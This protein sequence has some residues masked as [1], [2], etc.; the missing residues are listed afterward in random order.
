VF[1]KI[2]WSFCSVLFTKEHTLLSVSYSWLLKKESTA[3]ESPVIWSQFMQFSGNLGHCE[4][5]DS[6]D[7]DIIDVFNTADELLK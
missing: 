5:C 6:N 1:K 2:K 3:Q 4:I 7:S